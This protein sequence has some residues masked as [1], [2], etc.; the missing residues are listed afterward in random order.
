M[1]WRIKRQ[2]AAKNGADGRANSSE[3][4]AAATKSS[5]VAGIAM[6]KASAAECL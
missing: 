5:G 3:I 1:A 6:T 4:S 2:Q